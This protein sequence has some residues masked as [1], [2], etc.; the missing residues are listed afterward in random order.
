VAG[1]GG[2]GG[3]GGLAR[4]AD[5]SATV[6]TTRDTGRR[7][8]QENKEERDD[9]EFLK[10]LI[11]KGVH[12]KVI[13]KEMTEDGEDYRYTYSEISARGFWPFATK[14]CSKWK[15]VR[16]LCINTATDIPSFLV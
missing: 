9:T 10:K 11:L 16:Q 8:Q 2:H 4:V 3:K 5:G 6:T 14:L 7:E 12:M 15:I 1:A 13:T